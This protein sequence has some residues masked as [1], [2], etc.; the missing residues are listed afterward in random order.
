MASS[1]TS[2]GVGCGGAA[3]E[4]KNHHHARHLL[5]GIRPIPM[6]RCSSDVSDRRLRRLGVSTSTPTAT[7]IAS[8]EGRFFTPRVCSATAFAAEAAMEV[9]ISSEEAGF[10]RGGTST[11][12]EE[13]SFALLTAAAGGGG[14]G[15]RGIVAEKLDEWMRDSVTEIVKNLTAAPLLVHVY[16]DERGKK[17]ETEKAVEEGD[18][19]KLIEKWKKRDSPL[20]EGV[21][22]VEQLLDG[23][24]SAVLAAAEAEEEENDVAEEE[25][26]K[27]WGIVVQGKGAECG[28]VCYLLKTSRVGSSGVGLCCTH[29]CLMRVKSFRESAKSQLKNCWLLQAQNDGVF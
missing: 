26:T 7:P 19:K 10:P 8:G 14:G 4:L 18:W 9:E 16:S 1:S 11:A 21:I 13:S 28:P 27:A 23:G 2:T 29:F 25:A 12:A 3:T 17:L 20:P 22:F 6:V 5:A 24:R 15:E